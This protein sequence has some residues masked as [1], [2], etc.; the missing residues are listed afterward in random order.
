MGKLMHEAI[1]KEDWER[2]DKGL[3][4]RKKPTP[5]HIEPGKPV[6]KNQILV[7]SVPV[8]NVKTVDAKRRTVRNAQGAIS[9]GFDTSFGL[10]GGK[11]V[12]GWITEGDFYAIRRELPDT[13]DTSRIEF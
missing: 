1:D 12:S 9:I 5:V 11:K 6:I 8:E 4:P 2:I 13:V 10:N 3:R 7:H